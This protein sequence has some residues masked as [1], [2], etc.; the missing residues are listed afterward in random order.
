M[1]VFPMFLN[2]KA[3]LL[4]IMCI[5]ISVRLPLVKVIN[6]YGTGLPNRNKGRKQL[7]FAVLIFFFL[8]RLYVVLMYVICI[9]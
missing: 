9:Y 3:T 7:K 2:S 8:L 4:D 6:S 1:F 5:K